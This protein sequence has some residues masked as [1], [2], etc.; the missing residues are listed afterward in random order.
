MKRGEWRWR[1]EV[2]RGGRGKR[3]G[4]HCMSNRTI[5][6]CEGGGGERRERRRG[7]RDEQKRELRM[8]TEALEKEM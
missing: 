1:G 6:S 2:E 5:R 3:G 8:E 7:G 4:K